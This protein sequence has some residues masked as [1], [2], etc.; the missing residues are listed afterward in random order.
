LV[1]WPSD[2]SLISNT[3]LLKP[4]DVVPLFLSIYCSLSYMYDFGRLLYNLDHK[5]DRPSSLAGCVE[6][7]PTTNTSRA[8][9]VTRDHGGIGGD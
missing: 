6:I 8:D 5:L 7:L 4:L 1:H 3:Y 9:L 2:I